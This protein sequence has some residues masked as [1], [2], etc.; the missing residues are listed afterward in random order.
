MEFQNHNRRDFIKW[1]VPACFGAYIGMRSLSV[2]AQTK[3]EENL[4]DD[5]HKFDRQM[6]QPLTW[7]QYFEAEYVSHFI[8]YLKILGKEIGKEKVISSLKKLAIQE[9]EQFAK[10]FVEAKGRNDLSVFK[11]YGPDTPGIKNML[12]VEVIED[13]ENAYEIKITECLWAKVFRDADAVDYGYAAVC[14]GD[15]P[16]AQLVNPNIYL[17]LKGT[18]M[19]GKSTCYL[20]YYVK[21]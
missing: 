21:S 1:V 15:V 9:A 18:I 6:K 12:T 19:Q 14:S 11:Y 7:K 20:R 10:D 5:K 8:P 17:D 13:T 4:Q 3:Q 16:F 2:F